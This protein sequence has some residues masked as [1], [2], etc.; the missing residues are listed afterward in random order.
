[1]GPRKSVSKKKNKTKKNANN[2]V[3]HQGEC[4]FRGAV[5]FF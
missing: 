3:F 1:M 4:Q 5:F 2:V